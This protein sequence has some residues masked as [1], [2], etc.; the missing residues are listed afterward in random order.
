MQPHWL[1]LL[2]VR[3]K[4]A[5]HTQN[6]NKELLMVVF[7]QSFARESRERGSCQFVEENEE[8]SDSLLLRAR[9][10]WTLQSIPRFVV[11]SRAIAFIYCNTHHSGKQPSQSV[12]RHNTRKVDPLSRPIPSQARIQTQTNP[13]IHQNKSSAKSTHTDFLLLLHNSFRYYYLSLWLVEFEPKF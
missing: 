4:N 13:N 7:V 2:Q 6:T 8:S 3:P 9:F 12:S 10:I 1:L 11:Y 5:F